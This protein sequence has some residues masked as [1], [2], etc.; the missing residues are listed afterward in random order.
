MGK[1]QEC[2]VK[3]TLTRDI[4]LNGLSDISI[5]FYSEC[6]K[7]SFHQVNFGYYTTQHVS[8]CSSSF[9]LLFYYLIYYLLF[10]I[11]L[12]IIIIIIIIYY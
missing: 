10:L 9:F 7:T 1:I 4:Y 12:F 3:F 2:V 11:Y 8:L 5:N 6:L